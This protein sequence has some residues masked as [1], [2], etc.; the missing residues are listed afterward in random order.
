MKKIPL[1]LLL[2]AAACSKS[3]LPAPASKVKISNVTARTSVTLTNNTGAAV[4]LSGWQLKEVVDY[5]TTTTTTFTISGK[6]LAKGASI[7]FTTTE[8]NFKLSMS[9]TRIYLYDNAGNLVDDY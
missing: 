5:F 9:Y 6:T 4:D 7:S 2:L 8:L 3:K 1:L